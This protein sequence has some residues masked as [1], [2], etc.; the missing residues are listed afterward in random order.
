MSDDVDWEAVILFSAMIF[1][2]LIVTVLV[3]VFVNWAAGVAGVAVLYGC[4]L[5]SIAIG[6]MA[7]K[8]LDI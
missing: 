1:M 3:T 7:V 2:V 4:L 6:Y 5:V 8:Q